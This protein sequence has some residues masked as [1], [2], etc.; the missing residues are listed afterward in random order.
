V[1]DPHNWAK[2]HLI[3]AKLN[4]A[5]GAYVDPVLIQVRTVGFRLTLTC[6]DLHACVIGCTNNLDLPA[7]MG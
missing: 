1:A 7:C 3:C 4:V 2:K 5:A 6:M